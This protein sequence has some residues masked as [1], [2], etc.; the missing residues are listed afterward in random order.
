[1]STLI[2]ATKSDGSIT[3]RCD[4]RCYDTNFPTCKCIC[5]GMNHGKDFY[6]ASLNTALVQD[7][8]RSTDAAAHIRFPHVQHPLFSGGKT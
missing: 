7:T 8:Q 3:G 5:A 2:L 6:S 4:A 1:M